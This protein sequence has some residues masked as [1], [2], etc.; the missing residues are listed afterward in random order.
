MTDKAYNIITEHY[1]DGNNRY[2]DTLK[3]KYDDNDKNLLKQ[4]HKDT[5]LM[6]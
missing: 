3:D 5:E 2:M 4:L 1:S 6:V